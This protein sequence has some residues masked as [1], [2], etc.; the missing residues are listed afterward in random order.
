MW[1]KASFFFCSLY[2][3]PT[4]FSL[5][6]SLFKPSQEFWQFYQGIWQ[7]EKFDWISS[8]APPISCLAPFPHHV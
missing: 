7:I 3:K 6:L 4:L 1:I 2:S 5:S 8:P